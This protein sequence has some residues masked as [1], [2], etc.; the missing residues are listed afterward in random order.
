MNDLERQLEDLFMSDSRS[1]RV[2]QVNVPGPRRS[3]V[4]GFA[5]VGGVAMAALAV[6]VA[7]S[8]A[9]GAPDN[10]PASSPTPSG[11]AGVVASPSATG[12]PSAQQVMC[13]QISQFKAPTSNDSGSFVITPKDQSGNLVV[14]P[15]S[16]R[17]EQGTF[18]GYQCVKVKISVGAPSVILDAVLAPGMDGYVSDGAAPSSAPSQSASSGVKPDAQHGIVTRSGSG[19]I[20]RTEAS[21]TP[22][23][24]LKTYR[25]FAVTKDGRRVAYIRV[26]ETGEQ[27]LVFDTATPDVQKTVKDFGLE[28]PGGIVWSSDSN[29]EILVQVD[30]R[31]PSQPLA[32][33]FSSLR[34]I[35]VDTGAT[36]EIVRITNALLLPIVWHG[37]TNTGGAVETGDGGF[38]TSYDYISGGTLKKSPMAQQVGAFSIRADADGKRVLALGAFTGP[39]GVTWW[40]FDQFD[41][42]RE[43]K[44]ADGWDVSAAEW[45]FGTDEIVVFASP[46]VKGA[47]GPAPRIEAWTTSDQRRTVAQGT[48]PLADLRTDGTAAITTNW[49]LVDLATGNIN[50]MTPSDPT[51]TPQFAVKF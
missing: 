2:E 37:A 8:L 14:I 7:F 40:P 3:R 47:P 26:G 22:V 28:S 51:Q 44:P 38:A 48:G 31:S 17:G 12:A 6:I 32:V 39:R 43:L 13:G 46:T 29:D 30:K 15:P 24:T 33:E 9:R 20:V 34:A 41:A 27:L 36:R 25:A 50:A 23:T 45:R 21:A 19:G 35:N 16:A 10:V 1:R 18:S 5:F 4:S 42:K 11:S 49:N